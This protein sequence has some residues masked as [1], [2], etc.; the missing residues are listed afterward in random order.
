MTA[1]VDW[2]RT[3]VLLRTERGHG[4]V[5]DTDSSRPRPVCGQIVV[6]ARLLLW[7]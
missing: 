7:P 4:L 2:L 3:R 6:V 5:A 1:K